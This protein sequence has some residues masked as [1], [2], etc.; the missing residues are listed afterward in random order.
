MAP[1]APA[2][3]ASGCQYTLAMLPKMPLANRRRDR[4]SGRGVLGGTAK[5]PEAPHIET[6]MNDA[7]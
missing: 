6:K 5:I 7:E 4:R 2:P 3:A 1:D